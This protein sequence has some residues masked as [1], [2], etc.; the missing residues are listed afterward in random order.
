MGKH[1]YRWNTEDMSGIRFGRLVVTEIF[2]GKK[3]KMAKCRC[4]CGIT[5]LFHCTALTNQTSTSCGCYFRDINGKAI[6]THGLYKSKTYAT[7]VGIKHKLTSAHG[8]AV[9]LD[10]GNDFNL[11]R[12]WHKFENFLK[13]MGECPEGYMLK[14]LDRNKGYNP[15]NCKWVP[16]YG[17]W[18]S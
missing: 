15:K 12:S 4:D 1:R 6:I 18:A 3:N 17:R 13:D 14:R 8:M 10:K 16:R 9:M 7:W 5:K 2:P 11:P